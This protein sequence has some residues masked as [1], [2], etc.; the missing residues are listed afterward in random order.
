MT[1][2]KKKQKEKKKKDRERR[3]KK[4]LLHKRQALRMEAK[5]EYQ[6]D[7]ERMEIERLMREFDE[8][9]QGESSV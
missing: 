4:K 5:K 6:A 7:R 2:N 9:D 3:V 1:M 8:E